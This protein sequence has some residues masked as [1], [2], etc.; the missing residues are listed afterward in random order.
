MYGIWGSMDSVD[1]R[2]M[3][4]VICHLLVRCRS[5]SCSAHH[6]LHSIHLLQYDHRLVALLL[7]CIIH[8][9]PTVGRLHALV[10]HT[11]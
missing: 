9:Y 3:M 6:L 7:L 5:R 8:K 4:Y 11:Q 2:G 10:E 1:C